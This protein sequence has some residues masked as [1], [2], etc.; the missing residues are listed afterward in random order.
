MISKQ[1][2]HQHKQLCIGCGVC[3]GVCDAIKMKEDIFGQYYAMVN[4]DECVKCGKCISVC[5]MRLTE[6]ELDNV[7]KNIWNDK[8]LSYRY[9]SGFYLKCYEGYL[10]E[11]RNLSASGGYC[12]AL[13]SE[14][15]ERNLV[16]SVYCAEKNNDSGKLFESKRITTLDE[17]K[18]CAGSAYYPI[19]ISQTLKLIRQRKEKTAIV[20]LPCQATAIRL[21]MRNDAIL[22]ESISYI[23]GLIC[24]GVPGKGMIEYVAKDLPCDM[25]KITKITFREKDKGIKCNNC[26]LK[27]YSGD[28]LLG[29]SRFHGESFGFVYLNHIMHNK[30]CNVCTDIFAENSDIVFGDAW[31]DENKVNEYGTSICITRNIVLDEIMREMGA[32]ES[33]IDR[34]ILAQS[35]VGLI[36]KKK[37]MSRYFRYIYSKQGY[38]VDFEM[39]NRKQIKAFVQAVLADLFDANNRR[40]WARYKAGKISFGKLKKRW[41]F[42]I[43]LKRRAR[44]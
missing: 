39:Q 19:E 38:D 7:G 29:T 16:K 3:A 26:Q 34:I 33:T 2:V 11:Y 8:E 36:R 9:E 23:I 13:L 17:L 15:L 12:T 40:S 20:C 21:A 5:P 32:N 4:I 6:S 10:P 22:R 31:F 37:I 35:N 14:L 18:K 44:I 27:F 1:Y 25:N 42:N 43:S 28:K 24:G 30:G 41:K